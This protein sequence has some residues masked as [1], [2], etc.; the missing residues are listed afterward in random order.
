MKS[1]SVGRVG[2]EVRDNKAS[3]DESVLNLVNSIL[4]AGMLGF[5]FC[6]KECGIL[7]AVALLLLVWVVSLVSL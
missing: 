6:F 2:S 7:L 4:G 3:E 1:T 5:P